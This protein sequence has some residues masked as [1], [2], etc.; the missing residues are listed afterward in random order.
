MVHVTAC[1][2]TGAYTHT[3]THTHTHARAGEHY[4]AVEKK[5]KTTKNSDAEN[6][7]VVAH[8]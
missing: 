2:N 6:K 7:L 4:S 1:A 8:G 3:H 5:T